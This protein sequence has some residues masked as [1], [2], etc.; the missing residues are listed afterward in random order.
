VRQFVD[1]IPISP[2]LCVPHPPLIER[3][4][5]VQ[6]NVTLLGELGPPAWLDL[7][8]TVLGG[9]QLTH[10]PVTPR[11]VAR[12]TVNPFYAITIHPSRAQVAATARGRARRARA[13]STHA[14]L[15]LIEELGAGVWL[16]HVLT[17]LEGPTRSGGAS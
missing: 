3:A 4:V 14:G 15:A 16:N 5:W 17:A 10:A 6:A 2:D 12:M 13:A 9:G 7:F 11:D 1:G 8:C